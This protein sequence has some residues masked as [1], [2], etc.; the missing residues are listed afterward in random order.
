M[1]LMHLPLPHNAEAAKSR[2]QF[3]Y[4]QLIHHNICYYQKDAPEISDEAYDALFQ[5]AVA[6][7]KAFPHLKTLDSPT[8]SVGSSA[9]SKFKKV[10]HT[11]PMLS[12]DN[13]FNAEDVLAFVTR[14][15]KLLS[16]QEQDILEWMAEPKI[17]GLSATLR[18]ERGVLTL[19]ATRGDGITG[20]DITHTIKTI[21]TIPHQLKGTDYPPVLEIRGEVFLEKEDF[22]QLN[23]DREQKGLPLFANPRNAAAGS[24]RQLD[25]SIAAK[26]PLRFFAY[27]IA[28]APSFIH[29]QE[30]LLHHLKA[31]GFL[32]C[33]DSQRCVSAE[34]LLEYHHRMEEKRS[35]L[36]YDVDGVVYKINQLEYQKILGTISRS[37]RWALAHKFQASKGESILHNIT[38]QVGRTGVLTPVAELEPLNLGGV[39]VSRASLHNADEIKRKDIRIGDH[40]IVQRAGDVIPQIVGVVAGKDHE[41]N[42]PFIF[43][44][45]C[46]VCHSH[47]IRELG[48]VATRCTGGFN[49]PAQTKE[50][51]K[52]FVSRYA[53]NIEGLGE[54]NIEF[55]FLEKRIQ[56]PMDIF[57][58]ESC[59]LLESQPLK[60]IPGWGEKSA[61]SLFQAIR[62]KRHISFNRFLYALGIRHIGQVTA[63]SLATFYQTPQMWYEAMQTL[64]MEGPSGESFQRLLSID[65]IGEIIA[66]SL[67]E[68]FKEPS[69][70]SLVKDLID[71]LD[72]QPVKRVGGPLSG[73]TILFTG[74]LKTMTREEAKTRAESFGAKITSSLS[75]Q[76]DFLVVGENPGSKLQKAK[77]LGITTLSEQEWIEHLK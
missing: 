60:T 40:V 7:E 22:L 65:M 72:I 52:H 13:A 50:K 44:E 20:E 37:P 17:D 45:K 36:P 12:L 27:A 32:V 18:Y 34:D 21:R 31:W 15:R 73:K 68:Y 64:V 66:R 74:T 39:L 4:T 24:V 55:F 67:L 70:L 63:K 58:L 23:Q 41:R 1:N 42:P 30:S 26:R 25:S 75:R 57:T 38:V 49:C 69:N 2:L 71:F 76:T 48:E 9:E 3:L 46:P 61:V 77:Q 5:E 62:E 51:L 43:P 8:S 35:S 29:T 28:Q 6:I 10:P 33:S 59:D 11:I 56:N 47:A 14:V 19:A 54:K 16:F 53:F